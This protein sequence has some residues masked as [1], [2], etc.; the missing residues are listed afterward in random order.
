MTIT[1]PDFLKAEKNIHEKLLNCLI[2]KELH[3]F[4]SVGVKAIVD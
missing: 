1:L 3:S 2:Y 4:F